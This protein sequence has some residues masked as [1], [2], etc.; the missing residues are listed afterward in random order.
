M[1]LYKH[2]KLALSTSTKNFY[3]KLQWQLNYKYEHLTNLKVEPVILS[4]SVTNDHKINTKKTSRWLMK[5]KDK[6]KAKN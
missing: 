3:T 6:V 4:N 5:N 2:K 1:S